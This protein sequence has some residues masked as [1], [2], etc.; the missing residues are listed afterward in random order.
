MDYES[1]DL[2]IRLLE[3][4]RPGIYRLDMPSRYDPSLEPYI[5]EVSQKT[6]DY[7]TV[8]PY[9]VPMCPPGW[10]NDPLPTNE[11]IS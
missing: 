5:T 4:V 2:C 6:V 11:T 9:Q 1:P 3:E 10:P 7:L 8:S